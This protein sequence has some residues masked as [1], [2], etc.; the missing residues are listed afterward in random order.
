VFGYAGPGGGTSPTTAILIAAAFRRLPR[1][2]ASPACS[3][4]CGSRDVPPSA[5]PACRIQ[6]AIE[7]RCARRHKS[8]RSS[9]RDPLVGLH[10]GRV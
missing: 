3:I 10:R 2:P 8:N 9:G 5:L 7:S 1:S 6:T 4:S